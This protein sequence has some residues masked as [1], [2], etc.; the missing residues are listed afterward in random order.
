MSKG[1]LKRLVLGVSSSEDMS[2]SDS[3]VL[4]DIAL[5]YIH[6]D[7]Y[8]EYVESLIEINSLLT[9]R[10][11]AWK[12]AYTEGVF[13]TESLMKKLSSMSSDKL[14]QFRQL[15]LNAYKEN[16]PDLYERYEV[17]RSS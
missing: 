15:R 4:V 10:R 11:G 7:V 13:N 2:L 5:S 8:E 6:I 14:P 1:W 9:Y 16:E 12:G 17:I 3:L